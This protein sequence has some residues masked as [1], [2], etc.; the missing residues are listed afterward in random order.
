MTLIVQL[1]VA[2][3]I[4]LLMSASPQIA[5]AGKSG[6]AM[7]VSVRGSTTGTAGRDPAPRDHRGGTNPGGGVVVKDGKPHR[8]GGGLCA[9]WFC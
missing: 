1:T 6:S 5:Q 8:N 2:G 3:I 7:D 4:G 9:G